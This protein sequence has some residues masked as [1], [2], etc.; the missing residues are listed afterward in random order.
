MLPTARI[1]FYP[2]ACGILTVSF[3]VAASGSTALLEFPR[4]LLR[5]RFEKP[6]AA[7]AQGASE[8][9]KSFAE[10]SRNPPITHSPTT[11]YAFTI[12]PSLLSFFT[13]YLAPCASSHTSPKTA[14]VHPLNPALAII[15]QNISPAKKPKPTSLCF[16]YFIFS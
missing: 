13:Q 16:F 1:L 10:V 9:E 2:Y 12:S 14:L 8:A 11:N 3:L 5:F 6:P 7:C 15:L 4:N